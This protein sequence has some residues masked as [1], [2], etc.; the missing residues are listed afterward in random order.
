MPRPSPIIIPGPAG[1]GGRSTATNI[2]LNLG[3]I[4]QLYDKLINQPRRDE[5][6]AKTILEGAPEIA[7]MLGIGAAPAPEALDTSRTAELP[8]GGA[9]NLPPSGEALQQ[10]GQRETA[11]SSIA[12]SSKG[13]DILS[14]LM[15][16]RTTRKTAH[17]T[18]R[19]KANKDNVKSI[20]LASGESIPEGW[21]IASSMGEGVPSYFPFP[22]LG[23]KGEIL[24]GERR[25]G[26]VSVAEGTPQG[27]F[28]PTQ[29][30]I[31]PDDRIAAFGES[32]TIVGTTKRLGDIW[33]STLTGPAEGNVNRAARLIKNTPEFQQ[34][35]SLAGQLRSVVYALS[36]KQINETEQKWLDKEILPKITN[37]DKNFSQKYGNGSKGISIFCA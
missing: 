31:M 12:G 22:F 16:E 25:K 3:A 34:V 21:E 11:I 32:K 4:A 28:R 10:Q 6:A 26:T 35:A 19:E 5:A 13:R 8:T 33:D 23:P 27:P 18:I 29:E 24:L 30:R 17:Y 2:N 1:M 20:D 14:D 9:V 36:G 7:S 15:K 37:P